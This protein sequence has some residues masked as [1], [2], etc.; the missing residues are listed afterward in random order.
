MM[1][2]DDEIARI[3]D[4]GPATPSLGAAIPEE[5]DVIAETVVRVDLGAG[6][7]WLELAVP[8][9]PGIGPDDDAHVCHFYVPDCGSLEPVTAQKGCITIRTRDVDRLLAAMS[10][11]LVRVRSM[12]VLPPARDALT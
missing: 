7:G 10:L 12:G 11:A 6:L 4:G 9:Q 8:D 5:V 3:L 2:N 1:M